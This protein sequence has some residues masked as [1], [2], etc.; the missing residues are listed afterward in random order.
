[1]N[2]RQRFKEIISILRENNVIKGITPQKLCLIFSKLGPTFIKIGQIMSTRY[3]VLPQEYC[4]ELAKLRSSV[5]PMS[6]NDVSKILEEEL[7]NINN[8]FESISQTCIGSASI[9]QVHKARLKTGESVAV[10]IQRKNVY[11]TMTMDVKLFKKAINLLHLNHIIKI[12]DLNTII[13]EIYNVAKEE[14]NF[15]L[16]ANHLEEFMENNRDIAYVAVPKVFKNFVTK[17]VLVMEY[18]DGISLNE[19]QQ[20]KIQGYDLEE[21]GLK[22]SNNYIKQALDD[23]FFH[24]DPHQDNIYIYEGKIVFLDLGMMGRISN[25]SKKILNNAMK[26]IVRNDIVELEHV[27]LSI[28]TSLGEIDHKKLRNEIKIVLD[29]NAGE[30]IQNI[31]IIEFV[32]SVSSVLRNNNLKLDNNITLLLR[33]ICVI[34]GTLEKITPNIN[35]L[36]VFN[37][38][39]KENSLDEISSKEMLMNTSRN[40]INGVN[41]FSELPGEMLNLVR[42]VNKG[43]IKFD[44]EMANSNKQVNKL[45]KMLHQLV[46]GVLDAAMLLGASIVN[47]NIIRWIYLGFAL[48]F[49]T[50]LFIQ[51]FKDHI[52]NGY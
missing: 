41:N 23:G 1:M 37:N 13:D 4:N 6:F 42:D 38:K 31:N 8:I 21:I 17:K 10:K 14:M 15:E 33:G 19:V 29:K 11:E 44:V 52:H 39:I 36:I 18:I 51:M 40:I 16:E 27:L 3:D 24:A 35:L 2:E 26:A 46:V 47:N 5:E 9:A 25:R 45:E 34:E 43:E 7:G 32:N 49:S 30:D 48:L 20:L 50:W 12:I 22:L 28:S